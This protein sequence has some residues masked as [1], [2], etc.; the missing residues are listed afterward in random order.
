MWRPTGR[1]RRRHSVS[2]S[3]ALSSRDQVHGAGV[4]VVGNDH[5]GRGVASDDDAIADA[6]ALVT[7][8][9]GVTLAIMVA[10]C[11]P[12]ALVDPHAGVLAAVHAGWRGTAAGVARGALASMRSLGAEPDASGP[13]SGPPWRPTGIRYPTRSTTRCAVPL[14]VVRS[15]RGW[16]GPMDPGTGWSI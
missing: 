15:T 16:P 6:D 11:V 1:A 12:L 14:G 13:T 3:T 2:D 8:A 4:S 5:G 10:D 7:T 9:P